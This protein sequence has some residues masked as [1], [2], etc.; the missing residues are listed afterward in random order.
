MAT[1]NATVLLLLTGFILG[2][3][4]SL[5]LDAEEQLQRATKLE[6]ATKERERLARGIHDS[7]LQVLAIISKRAAE[8]GCEAAELGRLAGEQEATLRALVSDVPPPPG[9]G[10]ADLRVRLRPFASALGQIASP[11]SAVPLPG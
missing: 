2:Y 7:V 6:A 5:A 3:V 10:Q 4:V 11:A 9:Q 8:L 1:V